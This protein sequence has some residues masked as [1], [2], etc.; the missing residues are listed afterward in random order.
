[1]TKKISNSE[2]ADKYRL[3]QAQRLLDAYY[4][5]RPLTEDDSNENGTLKPADQGQLQGGETPKKPG[6]RR[7]P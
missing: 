2:A 3:A 6:K 7:T 5:G 4:G 1:M